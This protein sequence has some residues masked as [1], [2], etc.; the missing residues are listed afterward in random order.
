MSLLVL[1]VDPGFAMLGFALTSLDKAAVVPHIVEMSLVQTEKSTAK[2]NVL[3]SNDN[4]R[5]ARE[6]AKALRRIRQPDVVCVESMSFP[7]S[8]SVAAKMAM[9]WG[10]LADY[11]ESLQIPLLMATPKELKRAVTG[12]ATATKEQVQESLTLYFDRDLTKVPGM[13]DV[14]PSKREHPFDALAAVVACLN[15]EV[16]RLLQKAHV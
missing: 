8:A 3:A 13:E 5:R 15:G 16:L 14:P 11:C 6:I 4:F 9:S 12:V 10:V 7:R 2:Q 1:G